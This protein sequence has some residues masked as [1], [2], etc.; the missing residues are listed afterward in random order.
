MGLFR[1]IATNDHEENVEADIIENL[2][3]ILNS[4]RTFSTY[5]KDYGVADFSHFSAKQDIID[6]VMEEVEES[7]NKYEP[8][9][10]VLEMEELPDTGPFRM[11]FKMNCIIH[12]SNKSIKMVFDS[13]WNNFSISDI[14]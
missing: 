9:V 8:R 2:N 11:S 7:I 1:R 14:D 5:L 10:K 4:K 13:L 3:N 12:K 6:A